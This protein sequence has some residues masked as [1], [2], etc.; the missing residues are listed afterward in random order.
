[1]KNNAKK[2]K[3][4]SIR[5]LIYNDKYLIICS[6]FA[7]LVIWVLTSMN[8]S[9]ETTKRITVPV[10]VDFSGTLA[11]QLGIQ[12]YG[13]ENV[14]VEVT[15]SCK[16]YIASE[17]SE[18][19]FSAA[20]Q[21]NSITT[22]GYQSV[23]I[24]LNVTED[25]EFT[26]ESYAPTAIMGFYDYTEELTMP[27]ELNFVNTNFTAE[28]YVSGET[29]LNQSSVILRGARTYVSNVKR[30]VAD[31][32]LESELS[33]SQVVSLT[34][35]ALNEIGNKIDNVE[36]IIPE[37]ESALT[38][39]VPILKVQNLRP[40]VSFVAG[41][42]NAESFLDVKY[43]VNSVE[44]GAP[45]SAQLTA[46]NLGTISF[47][48][49]NL[50]ENTFDFNAA[51]INGVTVLDGTEEITVTVTVPKEYETKKIPISRNDLSP[52]LEGYDITVN[53]ISQKQITI[54]GDPEVLSGIDKS[55]LSFSL[56]PL[57]RSETIDE[58]TERCR[59]TVTISGNG[60]CWV[61]GM[62][63][64]NVSVTKK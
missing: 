54:V 33:E 17:I 36:I 50:G 57:E 51:Q 27:V 13:D 48:D 2:N 10:S 45:E 37:G 3:K 11:E 35:I 24:V 55:S 44:V 30:V 22:T 46:L 29:T 21:T 4:F 28:G 26:V 42:N 39:S 15:I 59:L 49:I 6:I 8:L 19:D 34:P 9:P 38:A 47:S 7:A 62:Y 56:V 25:A 14:N 53:S 43:S 61:L 20:L 32:E 31:I 60:R 40:A 52:E 58:N 41:P 16:K 64:V 12:Y 23:P 63:T 1:M 18:N 5:K